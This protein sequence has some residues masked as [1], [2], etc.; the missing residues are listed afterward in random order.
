MAAAVGG[1]RAEPDQSDFPSV[2][3]LAAICIAS[4]AM[5]S[6]SLDHHRDS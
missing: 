3:R 6:L 4:F 1:K 2:E 5:A